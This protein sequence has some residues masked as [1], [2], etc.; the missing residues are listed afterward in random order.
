MTDC[1]H[2]SESFEDEAAYLRHLGDE[3][4][5]EMGPIE[6]R[7]LDELGGG[8]GGPSTPLLVAGI[9]VGA[10][11][12]AVILYTLTIGGSGSGPNS[13]LGELGPAPN[14]PGHQLGP[15]GTD[16]VYRPYSLG[17][18]HEHGPISVNV[19]GQQIDFR[20][21]EFQHPREMRAFHFERGL[22]RWHVHAKGVTLEYALEATAFGV[23]NTSFAY[24]GVVYR[25][26]ANAQAPDGWEV[27]TGATVVY[28]V[29][30]EPVAP[31]T[32]VLQEG[33]S[34]SVRVQAPGGGSTNGTTTNASALA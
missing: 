31:E 24:D 17:A 30:G 20:R 16:E 14:P 18:A 22:R 32:Y 28:E 26:G 25:Q 7:R 21:A 23:T 15:A 8:D 1:E 5:G 11:L 13:E 12:L 6:R 10:L 19:D 27:V 9:A 29:N 2:C 3:H 34:I 4:P 33:D